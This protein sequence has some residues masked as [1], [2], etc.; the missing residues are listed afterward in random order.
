MSLAMSPLICS[1]KSKQTLTQVI[2]CLYGRQCGP[3]GKH[4][5]VYDSVFDYLNYTGSTGSHMPIWMAMC[6]ACEVY[7][8]LMGVRVAMRAFHVSHGL[9][10]AHMTSLACLQNSNKCHRGR[11]TL[12]CVLEL[13]QN[14]LHMGRHSVVCWAMCCTAIKGCMLPFAF[15]TSFT[16]YLRGF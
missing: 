8:I 5:H 11:H 10:H 3:H 15:Q 12:M 4:Q 7:C 9:I 6:N 13:V 14:A 2:T 16:L 1:R